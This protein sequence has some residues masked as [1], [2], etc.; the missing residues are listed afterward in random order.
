MP[1][2]VA[3]RFHDVQEA[4]DWAT[5]PPSEQAAIHQ[6]VSRAIMMFG[7][8]RPNYG[9]RESYLEGVRIFERAAGK[10]NDLAF[11]L[12]V[13]H[14]RLR[15]NSLPIDN[16]RIEGLAQD[17]VVLAQK[18][19][20][21]DPDA[22]AGM[23]LDNYLTQ[24]P[25]LD[26][27]GQPIQSNNKDRGLTGR[28]LYIERLTNA[29]KH[30]GLSRTDLLPVPQG[31]NITFPTWWASDPKGMRIAAF[32]LRRVSSKFEF[33]A[34]QARRREGGRPQD[35]DKLRLIANAR[36][37]GVG[38]PALSFLMASFAVKP[39]WPSNTPIPPS[40]VAMRHSAR[41][42]GPVSK[43]ERA[44]LEDSQQKWFSRLKE[45]PRDQ[46]RKQRKDADAFHRLLKEQQ[47]H[48]GES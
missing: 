23:Y 12:E 18:C 46:R 20:C 3:V 7:F 16:A 17:L 21:W 15:E 41:P 22:S 45:V 38:I 47:C 29:W 11:E 28:D 9:I 34:N 5:K 32:N 2:K 40:L 6:G 19:H 27:D 10:A 36:A 26:D 44:W 42:A 33:F 1:K 31:R 39:S 37:L 14:L 8:S 35:G 48:V 43:V 4:I 25:P 30:E 24:I 13:Q